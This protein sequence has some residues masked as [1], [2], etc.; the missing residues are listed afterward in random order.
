MTESAHSILS[1]RTAPMV[2]VFDGEELQA[3]ASEGVFRGRQVTV[4]ERRS[5]AESNIEF[6]AENDGQAPEAELDPKKSRGAKIRTESKANQQKILARLKS[7]LPDLANDPEAFEVFLGMLRR[8]QR[9]K[10]YRSLKDGFE[11]FFPDPSLRHGALTAVASIL[12][13]EQGDPSLLE[14]IVHLSD[15]LLNGKGPEVRS[16]YNISKRVAEFTGGETSSIVHLRD[17]YRQAVFGYQSSFRAYEFILQNSPPELPMIPIGTGETRDDLQLRCSVNFLM[18]CLSSD[19]DS[20]VPS[21]DTAF[22][23]GVVDGVRNVGLLLQTQTSCRALLEKFSRESGGTV[24]VEP[25]RLVRTLLSKIESEK[26]SPNDY[27]SIAV[28]FRIPLDSRRINFMTQLQALVRAFPSRVF[29]TDNHRLHAL[30]SIQLC[31][32]TLVEAE[33]ETMNEEHNPDA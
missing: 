18:S 27:G 7:D 29:P 32:D 21:R 10:E 12:N 8:A 6:A 3:L 1:A 15:Q 16:G 26:S 22:L 33:F 19:M 9:D 28:D 25:S 31:I 23:K 24:V 14:E 11:K 30:E 17:F 2:P 5:S 4:R 13:N 20:G